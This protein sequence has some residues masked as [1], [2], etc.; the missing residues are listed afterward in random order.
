[1]ANGGLSFNGLFLFQDR[2]ASYQSVIEETISPKETILLHR[3][4]GIKDY[5]L[6][7]YEQPELVRKSKPLKPEKL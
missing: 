3:I 6:D 5:Y 7:V 1:M 2:R 4:D